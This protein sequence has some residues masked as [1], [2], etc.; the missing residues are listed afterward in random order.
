MSGDGMED[1]WYYDGRGTPE[2]RT[3]FEQVLDHAKEID[4]LIDEYRSEE[5]NKQIGTQQPSIHK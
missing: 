5:L 2:Q 3:L 4:R 1:Y